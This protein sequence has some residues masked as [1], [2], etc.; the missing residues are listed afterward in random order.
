[1]GVFGSAGTVL[2]PGDGNSLSIPALQIT[3]KISGERSQAGSLFEIVAPAG[4]D[5]GAHVHSRSEEFFYVLDGEVDLLAFEPTARTAGNWQAWRSAGGDQVLRGGPGAM[6][7]VP[8][9]CPHAFANPGPAPVRL[10]FQSSPPPDHERYFEELVDLL[11]A[12]P[13]GRPEAI[14]ALRERYDIHQLT[15]LIPGDPL[16]EVTGDHPSAVHLGSE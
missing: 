1:V 2:R 12:G 13:E 3:L 16:P 4:F 8:A 7:H 11:A 9:G 10:L 15:P 14:A 5:V 6:M